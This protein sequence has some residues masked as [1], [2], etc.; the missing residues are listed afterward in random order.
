M[1]DQQKE[2]K[3]F[4]FFF[5]RKR[6]VLFFSEEKNQKTFVPAPVPGYGTWPDRGIL[7]VG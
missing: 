6:R 4:C 2:Q 7:S 1:S 5:V 3:S